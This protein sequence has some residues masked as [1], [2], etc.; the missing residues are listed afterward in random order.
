MAG[1]V[2][3]QVC[4]LELQK[5]NP[6]DATEVVHRSEFPICTKLG[7]SM[8]FF[9]LKDRDLPDVWLCLLSYKVDVAPPVQTWVYLLCEGVWDSW[10]HC[11][12]GLSK[13]VC[14]VWLLKY[15][16]KI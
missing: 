4:A 8:I 10:A 6:S 1:L 5:C 13:E 2:L 12:E 9:P 7:G 3:E 15:L 11:L 14:A 16:Q